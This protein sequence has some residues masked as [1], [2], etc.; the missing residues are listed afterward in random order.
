[1][2]MGS[3]GQAEWEGGALMRD[4]TG[5]YYVY[6]IPFRQGTERLWEYRVMRGD[7][8]VKLFPAKRSDGKIFDIR[9]FDGVVWRCERRNS[10]GQSLCL[11][12][13]DLYLA[14]DMMAG[15]EVLQARLVPLDGAPAIKGVSEM[16]AGDRLYWLR[17]QAGLRLGVRRQDIQAFYYDQGA[18]SYV[19]ASHDGTVITLM[20]NFVFMPVEPCRFRLLGER[21]GAFTDGSFAVA[22]TAV[23]GTSHQAVIDGKTLPFTFNGYFTS[24]WIE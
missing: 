11:A 7:Q 10:S 13:D 4:S 15:E 2:V 8:L 19:T 9:V 16:D 22:L 6:S 12:K 17:T 20:K 5:V 21:C 1:M 24:L 14:L 18:V 23:E 3:P